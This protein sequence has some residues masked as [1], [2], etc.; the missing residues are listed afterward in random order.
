MSLPSTISDRT[1]A[2]CPTSTTMPHHYTRSSDLGDS[3]AHIYLS[4]HLDDAA[5]SAGGCIARFAAAHQP[6]LVVNICTGSPD[7]AT[8]LSPFA[9]HLHTIWQLPPDEAV[10]R[11]IH[12][13][14]EALEILG[15]DSYQLDLLDAIYRRPDAY[16][17]NETLFGA[18][19]SDDPLPG[20]LHDHLVP[21]AARYPQAIFYAPLGVGNHVDHQV[22]HSAAV[23]LATSGITLAFY[24]DFPYAVV[25]GALETRLRNLGGGDYFLPIVTDID[26]TLPRKISA[27]EAYTSQLT[28]LFGSRSAMADSVT[29]YAEKLRPEVGTYGERIW[30]RR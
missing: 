29:G 19:A 21:L 13:D 5:L 15:A 3:Y 27:I 25:D 11:R 26:A 24:E 1:P 23:R 22:V 28:N 10:R 17:N 18:V 2:A 30:M 14:H 12:E 8:T 20:A 9:Q 6:V 16:V 7:L 4:P